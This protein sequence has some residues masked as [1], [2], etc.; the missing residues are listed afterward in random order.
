MMGNIRTGEKKCETTKPNKWID[1]SLSVK[2]FRFRVKYRA[3]ELF[4][5]F[6]H[7]YT[8]VL[9]HTLPLQIEISESTKHLDIKKKL[10]K[11]RWPRSQ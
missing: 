3:I 5:R 2:I 6:Y 1:T 9:D 7:K 4:V 11:T 10:L 8:I